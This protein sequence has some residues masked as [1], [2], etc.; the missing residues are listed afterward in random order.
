MYLNAV[1]LEFLKALF[2]DFASADKGYA[3]YGTGKV[4]YEIVA[5]IENNR[6]R[7]PDFVIDHSAWGLDHFLGVKFVR[8]SE[9]SDINIPILLGT[10][11]YHE[12]MRAEIFRQLGNPEV[13][14]IPLC[15][16]EPALIVN[17]AVPEEETFTVDDDSAILEKIYALSKVAGSYCLVGLR[18]NVEHFIQLLRFH[19]LMLPESVILPFDN[20]FDMISGIRTILPD[21]IRE[22]MLL[23]TAS[24][25]H[26]EAIL[27]KL[28]SIC[29]V[30]CNVETNLFSCRRLKY[31]PVGS[32]LVPFVSGINFAV[33]ANSL[34]NL[35]CLYCPG[36]SALLK[37]KIRKDVMDH[38]DI[39]KHD[40]LRILQEA[41]GHVKSV[42]FSG[43][44]EPLLAKDLYD[45]I[46]FTRR[47]EVSDDVWI[48]T[49]GLLLTEEKS[50]MLADAGLTR[51]VVSLDSLSADVNTC[52]PHDP[53]VIIKNLESF[54]RLT[55]IPVQLSITPVS[56]DKCI[57][58]LD[59]FLRLKE[60][61][62]TLDRV[63][64]NTFMVYPHLKK[65]QE[66]VNIRSLSY[67]E[68]LKLNN[69]AGKLS[70]Q[71][72]VELHMDAQIF[73]RERCW[74]AVCPVPWLLS[75]PFSWFL[76]HPGGRMS[77]CP[78]FQLLLLDNIFEKGFMEAMNGERIRLLIKEFLRGI[79]PEVCKCLCGYESCGKSSF[80]E[81][82][83]EK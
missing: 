76:V 8:L 12:Q 78:A 71:N 79:Y 31:S 29:K 45:L 75:T 81:W 49:N 73:P 24:K 74:G 34:C 57:S 68:F 14:S 20:T 3:L 18:R 40:A 13:I 42:S 77:I 56:G 19:N 27:D 9:L 51:L 39:N 2:H 64:V 15:R 17:S 16:E 43:L 21:S 46:R 60:R 33:S 41:K 65:L 6:L 58:E 70:C 28:N 52:R 22:D 62:P 67:N 23:V 26:S 10:N 61:I 55:K 1:Q 11:I 80:D 30:S 37:K 36:H 59:S 38:P 35:N 63:F 32:E 66:A 44:G 25:K 82:K 5:F 7:K 4:S 48:Q 50:C 54:S 69:I 83:D 47:N 72:G 53:D